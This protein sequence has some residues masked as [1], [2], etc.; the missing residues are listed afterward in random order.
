M[1]QMSQQRELEPQA[2]GIWFWTAWLTPQRLPRGY[3]P[4]VLCRTREP[5]LPCAD[6]SAA[7]AASLLLASNAVEE[8]VVVA[9]C[10]VV[11]D[12]G[13]ERE[14]ALLKSLRE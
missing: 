8:P 7:L 2:S 5:G 14:A 1:K 12:S 9:K 4:L 13:S 3:T 10:K 11:R 6:I